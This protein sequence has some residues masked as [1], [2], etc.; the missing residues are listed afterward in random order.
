MSSRIIGPY[1]Q[2]FSRCGN[3]NNALGATSTL[4]VAALPSRSVRFLADPRADQVDVGPAI[5][6]S[7]DDRGRG[8]RWSGI[9]LTVEG[10]RSTHHAALHREPI[11]SGEKVLE[12]EPPLHDRGKWELLR[13]P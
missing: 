5:L 3:V 10:S 1:H 8:E 11:R 4:T 7:V 12:V 2:S 13:H 6:L 9:V